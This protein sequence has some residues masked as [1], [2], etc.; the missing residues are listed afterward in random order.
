MPL[1]GNRCEGALSG[2]F[3]KTGWRGGAE[4]MQTGEGF[5][6]SSARLPSAGAEGLAHQFSQS[7]A[8]FQTQPDHFLMGAGDAF[9]IVP[10]KLLALAQQRRQIQRCTGMGQFAGITGS[11]MRTAFQPAQRHS[12][13]ALC[14]FQRQPIGLIGHGGEVL[15]AA[16]QIIERVRQG[17]SVVPALRCGTS[18]IPRA[19]S[20]A[21]SFGAQSDRFPAGFMGTGRGTYSPRC[22]FRARS[23]RSAAA[24]MASG[25]PR[26]TSTDVRWWGFPD[27]ECR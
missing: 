8:R 21:E 19:A 1:R 15:G 16:A 24:A 26:S 25:C 11:G 20:S 4:V 9:E 7:L 12:Q 13:Q 5:S 17:A 3:R 23:L 18:W 22:R 10:C 6:G 14:G 27:R 2:A